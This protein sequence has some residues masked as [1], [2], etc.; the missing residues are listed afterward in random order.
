MRAALLL[1]G[2][3]LAA[4]GREQWRAVDARLFEA[5][6]PAR[7]AGLEPLSGRNNEFGTF[8]DT[9]SA[10]WTLALEAG[11]S[12]YLAA[13]CADDCGGVD[14][15]IELPDGTGLVRDS[16]ARTDARLSFVSRQSGDH[17]VRLH[18]ARCAGGRCR[19]AA[20]LYTTPRSR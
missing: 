3:L 12:Y 11:R 1:G 9:A 2:C 10:R 6:A 7:E 19:W 4:C 15:A 5:A 17:Q 14:L 20:Q 13:A 16:S 8:A 18:V